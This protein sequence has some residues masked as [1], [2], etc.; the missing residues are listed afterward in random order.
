MPAK[1]CL[2]VVGGTG[3]GLLGKKDTLNIDYE[4]Q[5]DVSTELLPNYGPA[6]DAEVGTFG[7]LCLDIENRSRE[8]WQPDRDQGLRQG[9]GPDPYLQRGFRGSKAETHAQYL[10]LNCGGYNLADG[11]AQS[12]AI[13]SLVIGHPT[14]RRALEVMF[15]ELVAGLTPNSALEVWIVCS[16]AGGTGAGIHRFIAQTLAAQVK[17]TINDVTI[18]FLFVQC[19]QYTYRNRGAMTSKNTFFTIAADMAFMQLQLKHYP[20]TTANFF[21]FDLEQIPAHLANTEKLLRAEQ[22]EMFIKVLMTES[23][24]QDMQQQIVNME[25]STVLIFQAGYWGKDFDSRKKTLA[26]LQA[27]NLSLK[28]LILDDTIPDSPKALTIFISGREESCVFIDASPDQANSLRSAKSRITEQT[29][30]TWLQNNNKPP[31]PATCTKQTLLEEWETILLPFL[32]INSLTNLPISFQL[33]PSAVATTT[34]GLGDA[35]NAD[36][37]EGDRPAAPPI[38]NPQRSLNFIDIKGYE[39]LNTLWEADVT[40]AQETK[41]WCEYLRTGISGNDHCDLERKFKDAAEAAHKLAHGVRSYFRGTSNNAKLLLPLFRNLLEL[42]SKLRI[43]VDLEENLANVLSRNLDKARSVQRNV[44]TLIQTG[45]GTT[46][47]DSPVEISALSAELTQRAVSWLQALFQALGPTNAIRFNKIVD[48]GANGLSK[49]GLAEVLNLPLDATALQMLKALSEPPETNETGATKAIKPIWWK[50]QKPTLNPT[51]QPMEYVVIPKIPTALRT[52][53]TEELKNQPD[54]MQGTNLKLK[55][56]RF[57]RVGLY[58]MYVKAG[59]LNQF[60]G[61]YGSAP[62]Y[63]MKPF[64]QN[65]S[66]TLATWADIDAGVGIQTGD[67]DIA[68]AGAVGEPLDL[69]SLKLAGLTEDE[70][71][72]ISKYYLLYA[73][74]VGVINDTAQARDV[75][76]N[77]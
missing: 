13:G 52:E 48:N 55:Y 4:W 1:R 72:K 61:D 65:I 77:I 59:N 16:T 7:M 76:K 50:Q 66:T 33:R 67:F 34:H 58:V 51:F 31:D 68:C 64:V 46:V 15:T 17:T 23:A 24:K 8:D 73:R 30:N 57:G 39:H 54:F 11:L 21:Y 22:V 10:R 74:H 3:K 38:T 18:K 12:P 56:E 43:I 71:A 9:P 26:T 69:T 19:G 2:I 63:L 14:N 5:I 70:V 40:Q 37:T 36:Y 62:K 20:S 29:I 53:F 32:E 60:R 35:D 75:Y 28:T 47:H 45:G 6:L 27:L 44:A 49:T 42:A 25:G 41:A